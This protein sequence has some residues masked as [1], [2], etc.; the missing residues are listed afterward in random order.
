MNQMLLDRQIIR[1]QIVGQTKTPTETHEAIYYLPQLVSHMPSYE[2]D[3]EI[4]INK[5]NLEKTSQ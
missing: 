1:A 3:K 2:S 4:N 5:S